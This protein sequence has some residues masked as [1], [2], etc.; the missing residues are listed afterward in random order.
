MNL[1]FLSKGDKEHFQRLFLTSGCI[2]LLDP[3]EASRLLEKLS[4]AEFIESCRNVGMAE[5]SQSSKKRSDDELSE[6]VQEAA[7][8]SNSRVLSYFLGTKPD[9]FNAPQK[10]TGNLPL[11]TYLK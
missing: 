1:S 8:Y 5:I 2:D 3:K 7:R 4:K 6:C 11:H 10:E 9:L